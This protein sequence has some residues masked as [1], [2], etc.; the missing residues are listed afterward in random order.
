MTLHWAS[1]HHFTYLCPE[2]LAPDIRVGP[3][4]LGGNWGQGLHGGSGSSW[5]CGG[6][7]ALEAVTEQQPWGALEPTAMP[8]NLAA[9]AATRWL[10]K[11]FM[12]STTCRVAV[13]TWGRQ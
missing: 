11:D 10:G 6:K 13:V 1:A 2:H 7:E 8:L 4:D 5:Q 3:W 9:L 12:N